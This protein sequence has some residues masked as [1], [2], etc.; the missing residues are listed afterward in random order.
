MNPLTT[1][2]VG[3][4]EGDYASAG[5]EYRVRHNPNNDLV[6]F[7]AQ[8]MAEKYLKGFLQEHGLPFR[9]THDLIELLNLCLSIDPM[10]DLQRPNL[11]ILNDYSVRY[12]YPGEWANKAQARQAFQAATDVRMFM[13]GRLGLP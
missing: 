4:A 9:K 10:I 1:E 12:Y 7:L 11:D 8:Q 2:W 13:R 5:R 3:K 6:C